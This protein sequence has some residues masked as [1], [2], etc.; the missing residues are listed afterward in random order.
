MVNPERIR[1]GTDLHAVGEAF[2]D[3]LT[4]I[5]LP[6]LEEKQFLLLKG[7]TDSTSTD[8]SKALWTARL[9]YRKYFEQKDRASKELFKAIAWFAHQRGPI[10]VDDVNGAALRELAATIAVATKAED[11]NSRKDIVALLF[12][13]L[14]VQGPGTLCLELLGMLLCIWSDSVH[15]NSESSTANMFFSGADQF[16]MLHPAKLASLSKLLLQ[17]LSSNMGAYARSEQLRGLVSNR[18]LRIHKSW[19]KHGDAQR[20][21]SILEDIL[22]QCRTLDTKEQDLTPLVISRLTAPTSSS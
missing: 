6:I 13:A 18:V 20:D 19:S 2:L 15:C 5:E 14:H 16:S 8:F 21:L 7:D 9:V 1:A 22:M 10:D 12:E 17:D 11:S 4:S 3:C